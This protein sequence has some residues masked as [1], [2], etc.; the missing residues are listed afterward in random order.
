MRSLSQQKAELAIMAGLLF[1]CFSSCATVGKKFNFEFT[2]E[3]ELGKTTRSQAVTMLGPDYESTEVTN[4]DGSFKILSYTYAKGSLAGANVRHLRLEFKQDVLNAHVY[5][6]SFA[7]DATDFN[8]PASESIEI[9]ISTKENLLQ[10]L[11]KPSGKGNCPTTLE[12]F[13]SKCDNND[14]EIWSW[15]YI[16]PMKGTNSDTMK[17]KNTA[18]VFDGDG[19]VVD[20]ERSIET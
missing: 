12:D 7:E 17:R 2:P 15:I 4:K 11:G 1:L 13:N 6:S 3:L 8:Y 14:H 10:M 18:V 9:G 20:F 16:S 5:L 19:V